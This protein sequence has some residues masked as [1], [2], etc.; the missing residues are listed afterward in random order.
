MAMAQNRSK[1]RVTDTLFYVLYVFVAV[2]FL[3]PLLFLFIS[4]M[5]EETQLIS[6]MTT[7]KAFVPYG[8]MSFD[9]YVQVFEK[10]DFLHYFRNSAI[11]AILQVAI[12]LF[13]NESTIDGGDAVEGDDYARGFIQHLNFQHPGADLA[14]A[15]FKANNVNSNLGAIVISCNPSA[16]TAKIYGTPCAPLKMQ[17]AD[18]VDT[19]EARRQEVELKSSQR[20]AP[21][22]II[23]KSLIPATD[24]SAINTFLGIGV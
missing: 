20:S 9:N 16:T 17:K 10:I 4:A 6:D 23:A 3:A 24:N 22:G 18:E 15:E 8:N 21:V 12:G 5:K 13:V 2:L 19:N 1:K 7:L 14:F 11:N